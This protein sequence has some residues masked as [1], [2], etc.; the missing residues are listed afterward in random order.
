[1]IDPNHNFSYRTLLLFR[2]SVVS[3]SPT[4]AMSEN[5]DLN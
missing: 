1:M 2:L 3:S 5:M 4:M